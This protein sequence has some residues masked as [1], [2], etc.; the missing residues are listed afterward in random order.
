[1]FVSDS[2]GGIALTEGKENTCLYQ[3]CGDPSKQDGRNLLDPSTGNPIY[4]LPKFHDHDVSQRLI[5]LC[6]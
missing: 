3:E 4:D 1:M 5:V 6:R 2:A